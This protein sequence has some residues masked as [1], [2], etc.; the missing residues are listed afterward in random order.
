MIGGADVAGARHRATAAIVG[1]MVLL[2]LG[3]VGAP[4]SAA[5]AFDQ[6]TVGEVE[7]VLHDRLTASGVPGAAFVVVHRDGASSTG[8]VGLVGGGAVTSRTPFVIGSTS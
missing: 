4:A 2:L 1:A 5:Q 7:Q 8:G 3:V 6:R